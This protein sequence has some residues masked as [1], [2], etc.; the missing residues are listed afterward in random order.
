MTSLLITM[1]S[2]AISSLTSNLWASQ[3][4]RLVFVERRNCPEIAFDAL[5]FKVVT[6]LLCEMNGDVK[7]T[8]RVA[9][10]RN[11]FQTGTP[12]NCNR[13]FLMD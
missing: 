11:V 3:E 1:T 8:A 12:H 2:D 7:G 6:E 5:L 4:R 9:N 13:S 10:F